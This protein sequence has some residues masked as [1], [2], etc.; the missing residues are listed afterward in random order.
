MIRYIPLPAASDLTVTLWELAR[1]AHLQSASDTEAM[2]GFV[3]DLQAPSKRWLE[4][5]TA[6]QIYLH[7]EAE[8]GG[9]GP[10]LQPYIN[11]GTLP[12]DTNANLASTIEAQ[13]GQ[14]VTVYDLFPPFFQSASKTRA[15]MVAAG[16]LP[17][18]PTFSIVKR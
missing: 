8:L 14:L 5:D 4:V 1:P 12:A 3:D 6:F 10:I 2:F 13:R 17:G 16:W 15:E 18:D 7:P 9:I 11:N